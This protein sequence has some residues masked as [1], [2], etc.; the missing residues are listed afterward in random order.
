ML[1]IAQLLLSATGGRIGVR[2]ESLKT[3]ANRMAGADG[4]PHGPGATLPFARGILVGC[5]HGGT[6]ASAGKYNASCEREVT[7]KKMQV[8][9]LL[10]LCSA[11]ITQS[12]AATLAA[13]IK[14][15]KAA[16]K[17][18]ELHRAAR[19]GNA[20]KLQILLKKGAKADTRDAGGNTPL[21]Y[22]RTRLAAKM[23]LDHDAAVDARN[24]DGATPLH[25]ATLHGHLNVTRELLKR[26]ADV[27]A[28]NKM[29]ITPL[30]AAVGVMSLDG[31]DA[32]AAVGLGALAGAVAGGAA[33]T[34]VAT[35]TRPQL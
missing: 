33:G 20:I 1:I 10:L 29:G 11:G 3:K 5:Q 35:A 21:H 24:N 8:M 19:L 16:R 25:L 9:L 13:T 23:L 4:L 7:M 2:G 31:I 30:P 27:N 32:A 14:T 18:D 15:W 28:A 12:K 22:A 6:G 34:G 26:G 17:A